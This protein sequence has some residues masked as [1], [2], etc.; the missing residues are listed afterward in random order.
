MQ[1][2][3]HHRNALALALSA[4]LLT[5]LCAMAQTAGAGQDAQATPPP[6]SSPP[7]SAPAPKKT[8]KEVTVLGSMIPRTEIEGAAPVQVITGEQIKAQGYTTLY[9]FMNSLPQSTGASDFSSNPTTWGSTAV[10]ARPVDLRGLGPQYT[11]LLIDGQRVVDYPQPQNGAFSHYTFQNAANIPTGMIDRVEVLTGGDSAIYGSDAVAG[12]VN[13]ILKKRYQGDDLSLQMGGDTRGGEQFGEFIWT[14]GRSGDKWHVVYNFEHSNR[15]PL[16]GKDRPGYDA[17]DDAGYGTWNAS[18]RMFGYQYDSAGASALSMTNGNGTYVTP[19]AGSCESFQYF[20]RAESKTI[21]TSGDQ[22]TGPVTDN[23][24]FCAQPEIFRNWVLSP[25]YRTNN[26]YVYGEYDF[27]PSLSAYGSVALY[28]T[29]GISQTQRPFAYPMGGLPVPFYDQGTGQV[30]SS[31][32][33]QW[34]LAEMGNQGS[35]YD[36]E[37]NWDIRAGLKGGFLDDRFNWNFLLDAQK[38]IVHEDYTGLN[39]Q[40]MFNFLF[41]PQLGTTTVNGTTYPVYNVNQQRFWYPITPAEYSTFGVA[42]TNTASSRLESATF[43]LNGDLFNLPWDNLPLGWAAVLTADNQGFELSPDAR[44]NT[45]DFGDPFQDLNIARGTRQ[46]YAFGTEFRVPILSTLTWDI[47][48]RVDKYHDASIANIARTWHTGIEWRPIKSLLL[49]GSY[50]TNFRAPGM[51]AIYL[52]NSV[53]T[54]G[55]YGDPLQC[56][57]THQST[58]PD[59]QHSTFFNQYSGGNPNLLPETGKSWTYG[60]VWDIPH[61]QGLSVQADYWRIELQNQ[62]NWISL[63]TALTDEAGCRT[64]LQVGGAPYTAHVPGSAYCNEAIANVVRD[65]AGNIVAVHTGPI[66]EAYVARSGIDGSVDYNLETDHWGAFH[67]ELNYTNY[68]TNY[69]R[70]LASDPLVNTRAQN[71]ITHMTGSVHWNRGP[72]NATLYGLRYGGVRDNNYGGCETLP[73]GIQPSIGDAQCVIH[74]GHIKPWVI[75]SASV[76]YQFDKRVRMTLNVNNI[77]NKIGSISYYAGGFQFISTAQGQDY[78]G[79]QIYLTINYK[80]D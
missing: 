9:Q 79:R 41:G 63:G 60:F 51:D 78:A 5:P 16:W 77:F 1:H 76:G 3:N 33:R 36:N 73:N 17:V 31:Y 25:G 75:Y 18:A 53:S 80:L 54:V 29:H 14:G 2:A 74:D 45:L 20:R 19:P 67:F 46:H 70:T 43:N 61:V 26:G 21:G 38:Y 49:R 50:G 27:N 32:A 72:W 68:L 8:L 55:D 22:V 69:S 34:T 13:I 15:S 64:G 11:L 30:I 47:A 71:V 42:G 35:T 10:N 65:A 48:G 7:S 44:G 57:Q 6:S 28:T 37:Q 40:G 12:V 66:N 24:S 58:C 4:A 56:I 52:Q 23:G 39:E 62:I 59:V